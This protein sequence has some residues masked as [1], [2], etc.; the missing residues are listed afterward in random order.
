MTQEF[1]RVG[2]FPARRST[3][4]AALAGAALFF[5]AP[6]NAADIAVA[7]PG[8]FPAAIAAAEA[9]DRLLLAP[10]AYGAQEI[11]GKNFT[12][13]VTIASADLA[14]PAIFSSMRTYAASALVFDGLVFENGST[15]AP[16]TTNVITVQLGGN[17]TFRNVA[18]RGSDDGVAGND[19]I[20]ISLRDTL[21]VRIEDSVFTDLLRGIGIVDTANLTIQNN[22]FERMGSDGIAGGGVQNATIASNFIT[23]FDLV[24]P[25]RVHPDGIQLWDTNAK[26]ANANIAITGNVILRGT[27]DPAQGIFL[28]S[29]TLQST[30]LTI[31]D[32]V[33]HQ[34]MGQGIYVENANQ[35][36]IEHNTISPFD[37]KTDK[38]G[39]DLRTPGPDFLFSDNV[40]SVYRVPAGLGMSNE[41]L[42][43]DNPWIEG[44]AEEL[45]LAPFEGSAAKAEDLTALTGVG[46]QTITVSHDTAGERLIRHQRND[47]DLMS[48]DYQLLGKQAGKRA[49]WSLKGAD[50]AEEASAVGRTASLAAEGPGLK[51]VSVRFGGRKNRKTGEKKVRVLDEAIARFSFDGTSTDE[52]DDPLVL[53]GASAG[54]G[55]DGETEFAVFDGRTPAE[56][57]TY[58]TSAPAPKATS[59]LNLS[60]KARLRRSGANAVW[61]MLAVVSNSYQIRLN[62]DRIQAIF[63][64]Q[65]GA[66]NFLNVNSAGISDGDWHDLE[67]K[68]DGVVGSLALYV[69]GTML[70]SI[71]M[72]AG[73]IVYQPKQSLLIGG[74]PWTAT[75]QGDIDRFEISR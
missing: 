71:T 14:A 66:A 2:R 59:A 23:N 46:A 15:S 73:P 45:V 7:G 70:N 75:F 56:G 27:G 38:P 42:N 29:P 18:I 3:R 33:I 6:A 54:F 52:S 51:S 1:N 31:S 65:T 22:R 50:G 34:S 72:P 69:D 60:V 58:L 63:Y 17:I 20:G 48:A 49:K 19:G 11:K 68:Y 37:W 8:D 12:S 57:G 55:A 64:D 26:A 36:T 44:Y 41:T 67:V 32:N 43:F 62:Q 25:N 4:I 16:T 28:R 35:V 40:A 30:N 39:F 13:P 21:D 24:D 5:G 47:G 61:Q 53:D 74:A 9:G 10:G